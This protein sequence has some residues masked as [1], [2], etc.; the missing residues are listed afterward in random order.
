MNLIS[1]APPIACIVACLFSFYF[2]RRSAALGF[3]TTIAVGYFYGIARANLGGAF[4]HFIFDFAAVG[5]FLALLINYKDVF[6]RYKL[7]KVMPWV[8]ILSAWPTLLL[9]APTQT[10]PVE[11]VGLRGHIFFLPFI[12]AGAM[13]N[14]KGA[15]DIAL[16]LAA[17]NFLALA[18]ALLEVQFGVPAFY[19]FNAVDQTIYR[20]TDVFVGGVATFRIPAIFAN[21]AAYGANMIVAL[22]FLVGALAE[23]RDKRF[24]RLFISAIVASVIGVFLCGSRSA[25][26]FLF[27]LAIGIATSGRLRNL[28]KF[29]WI[30]MVAFVS[31]LVI[32]SSRMQRFFTLTDTKYVKTR[33]TGSVNDSFLELMVEYPMGN[34]LGGGGTSLPYFLASQ[35][36]NPILIENEYGRILLEQGL[37]GLALWLAFVM[38]VLTRPLPKRTESWYLGRWLARVAFGFS[39]AMAPIGTGLL[40]SIP[41]TATI[42]LFAGWSGSPL[43]RRLAKGMPRPE[44][45]ARDQFGKITTADTQGGLGS[46]KLSLPLC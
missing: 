16:G 7:R 10:L 17:L 2:G 9:L 20:S 5:Y 33:V 45:Q 3:L 14:S 46:S 26:I 21:A 4:S 31:I 37:P 39:F 41:G 29:S 34:G 19:P 18:F 1:I 44:V 40:T 12:A 28:P 24:R 36:R 32:S 38:W 11:L 22:P 30:A 15:R 35:V 8:V 6:V 13:L 27:A 23:E 25:V 42:L 43:I